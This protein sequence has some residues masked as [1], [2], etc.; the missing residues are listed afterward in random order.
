MDSEIRV[1]QNGDRFRHTLYIQGVEASSLDVVDLQ[2][3]LGSCSVRVGGI[4]NVGTR[5]D[6]RGK[7]YS[8]MLLQN[9][10]EWLPNEGF[11]CSLL[12]G[13]TDYYQKF[14]YQVC[15]PENRI[16]I[17]TRHAENAISTLNHRPFANADL[18]AVKKLHEYTDQNLSGS[19]VRSASKEWFRRGS[20]YM[21][22]P[23]VEVFTDAHNSI[24]AYI[25]FDAHYDSNPIQHELICSEY[26][27]ASPAYY[28]DLVHFFAQKALAMRLEKIAF[29][30]PPQS[31]FI[32]LSSLFG[33]EQHIHYPAGQEGMGR[34]C[35]LTRFFQATLSEWTLQAKRA[36]DTLVLGDAVRF[37]TEIGDITLHL[38]WG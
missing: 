19:I 20:R 9:C 5:N 28:A 38:G 34:L 32:S 18:E 22:Q 10:M 36:V 15:L 27:V 17:A 31:G 25:A 3:R 33:A 4:A 11:S 23:A 16:E 24:V 14:G 21:R 37:E 29:L 35:D 7:G 8:R 26:G 6:Y 13:I 1:T 2:M 30:C 12:F